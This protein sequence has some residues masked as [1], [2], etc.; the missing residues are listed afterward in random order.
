MPLCVLLCGLKI[1][2][3]D[4]VFLYCWEHSKAVACVDLIK[5]KYIFSLQ[6]FTQSNTYSF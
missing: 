2:N 1:R 6:K 4:L 3:K 5:V